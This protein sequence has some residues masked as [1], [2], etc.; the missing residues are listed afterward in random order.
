[1][2]GGILAIIVLYLFLQHFTTTLIVAVSIPLSVIATFAPLSI[3]HVS[4]NIMSLGGLALGIG[5][6]VD[7]SIVVMES[8]FRCREEG[9]GWVESAIRG[10]SEVG[11]AV[12]A[13]TLTTVAVFFPIVFVEGI[14]GQIFGDLSLAV[15]FSLLASLMVSLFFIPMLASRKFNKPR[16]FSLKKFAFRFEKKHTLVN[17]LL[18]PVEMVKYLFFLL[19]HLVLVFLLLFFT[20]GLVFLYPVLA[21]LRIHNQPVNSLQRF[22][23][24]RFF[25]ERALWENFM[26]LTPLDRYV[27]SMS[28]RKFFLL[29]PWVWLYYI[30]RFIITAF[31]FGQGNANLR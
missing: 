2:I 9:D 10:V 12:V 27:A 25:K 20:A 29:W 8:I 11:G 15:V 22:T 3:F 31:A 7:N 19:F 16:D 21:L 18:I 28:T 1:M 24:K 14:A 13:S 17:Y 5:M 26:I 6:L 4:L 30:V 23:G